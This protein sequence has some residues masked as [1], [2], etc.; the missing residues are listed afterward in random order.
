M[1]DYDS[2]RSWRHLIYKFIKWLTSKLVLLL[3]L[4]IPLIVTSV[5]S[6]ADWRQD[7]LATF[8]QATSFFDDAVYHIKPSRPGYSI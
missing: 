2:G 7:F 1:V 3:A 5:A 6:D 8:V 4:S